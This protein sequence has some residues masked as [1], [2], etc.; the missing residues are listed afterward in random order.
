[1]LFTRS[2]VVAA[3]A[4]ALLHMSNASVA[5]EDAIE[6]KLDGTANEKVQAES[7]NEKLWRLYQS[8]AAGLSRWLHTF[9]THNSY[10]ADGKQDKLSCTACHSS[11]SNQDAVLGAWE[12]GVTFA[13]VDGDLIGDLYLSSLALHGRPSAL[14]LGKYAI[15][16]LSDDI[17]RS[18]LKL[19]EEVPALL[20]QAGASEDAVLMR[21]DVLLTVNEKPVQDPIQLR[22][23][24]VRERDEKEDARVEFGVIR[25]GLAQNVVVEIQDITPERSPFRIG[26]H[27][28]SPSDAMRSQLKLYEN[29][30]VIVSEVIADSPA[31]EAGVERFDILLRAENKRVSTQD[32]LR[33]II[34]ESHGR[35]IEVQ[36]MRAGAETK[37]EVTPKR[38]LREEGTPT[39]PGQG[40]W[41]VPALQGHRLQMYQETSQMLE[42]YLEAAGDGTTAK[43]PNDN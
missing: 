1:M 26:V 43:K 32:D 13:D 27:L 40:S 34:Q 42:S 7:E 29:E 35:P 39:C 37:L 24:L 11:V 6:G 23:F 3:A 8:D 31:S 25:A 10:H 38:A 16:L 15:S 19:E 22:A 21:G 28:E 17:L 18:H 5:Q 14:P 41:D 33:A 30:G 20:V 4:I 9:E 2:L 36:L 12:E